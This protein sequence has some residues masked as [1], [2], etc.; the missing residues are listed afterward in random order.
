MQMQR[1]FCCRWPKS[2]LPEA[3]SRGFCS[4]FLSAGQDG[5]V[6]RYR[7]PAAELGRKK[8]VAGTCQNVLADDIRCGGPSCERGS[9]QLS[10]GGIDFTEPVP[11]LQSCPIDHIIKMLWL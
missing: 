10:G 3:S 6:L 8:R 11:E 4:L 9:G 5:V 2:G 7:A 1:P